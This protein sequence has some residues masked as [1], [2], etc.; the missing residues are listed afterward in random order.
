MR[1]PCVLTC[2]YKH[3]RPVQS[4]KSRVNAFVQLYQSVYTV[5]RDYWRWWVAKQCCTEE[6]DEGNKGGEGPGPAGALLSGST[7]KGGSGT[8]A[9]L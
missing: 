8:D 1:A 4:P 6:E 5:W 3:A 9:L 2:A 7:R